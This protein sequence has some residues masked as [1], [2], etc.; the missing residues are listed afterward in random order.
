MI[1]LDDLR[2]SLG[3][4]GVNDNCIKHNNAHVV[5][6]GQNAYIFGYFRMIFCNFRL[7]FRPARLSDMER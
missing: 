4:W 6:C 3:A 7:I 1:N 2:L 5:K